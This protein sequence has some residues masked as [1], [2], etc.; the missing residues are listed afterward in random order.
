MRK[1]YFEEKIVC[2]IKGRPK[3]S[4]ATAEFLSSN[5]YRNWSLLFA[6]RQNLNQITS[7]TKKH[8][9]TSQYTNGAFPRD[10]Y[11]IMK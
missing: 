4:A 7:K 11:E 9:I 5:L 3:K 2:K 10:E 8:K 6:P 1:K